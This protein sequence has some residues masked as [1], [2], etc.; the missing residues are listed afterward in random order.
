MIRFI[1][2][3]DGEM[4]FRSGGGITTLSCAD[5]EYQ[6]LLEKIYVPTV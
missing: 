4:F 2:Q 3:S 6:E 1:E 5:D